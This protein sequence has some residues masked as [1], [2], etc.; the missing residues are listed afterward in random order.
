MLSYEQAIQILKQVAQKSQAMD[1]ENI[2]LD[3]A[4]GR[5][6]AEDISAEEQNPPFDQSAMDGFAVHVSDLKATG[7]ED[8][9][10]P[11]FG[12][13]VAGDDSSAFPEVKGVIEIMTG[14]S[15]PSSYFD[16]V[17]RVE[18]TE[19]RLDDQ[20]RLQVRFKISPKIGQNIR[21]AGE[22]IQIG[23]VLLRK[24]QKKSCV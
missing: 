11:V 13:V 19:S 10:Y 9:W 15:I 3:Q 8:N 5:V 18:D 23:D 17:I 14:A 7:S 6:A 2:P 16:A 21:L 1:E 20:G 4:V 24:N 22:D 12:R